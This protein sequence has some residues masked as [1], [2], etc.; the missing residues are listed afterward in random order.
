[1]RDRRT[2]VLTLVNATRP[3]GKSHSERHYLDLQIGR[4]RLSDL[5]KVGD[6]AS[7]LGWLPREDEQ[8]YARQLLL[9]APSLFASGRVPLYICPECADLGCGALTVRVTR[10]G[11]TVIG[12]D[13]R[14]EGDSG[15]GSPV[16][17]VREIR[18]FLF[19]WEPY[20]LLLCPFG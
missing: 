2:D 5:I 8:A 7:V 10:E 15:A 11:E 12:S 14:H 9:R 17:A 20:R 1:V 18:D 6:R 19:E 16:E 13:F 3:G 4:R